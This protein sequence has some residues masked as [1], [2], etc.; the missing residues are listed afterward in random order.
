VNRQRLIVI[1]PLPPPYHGVTVSTS[2]VL[3]NPVLCDRFEVDH[4]DTSDHRTG[5]NIGRW[6]AANARLAMLAVLRLAHRL[7]GD[8]GVVYLPLSQSAPGL[9]RDSLFVFAA[10]LRGWKVAIHLRG[11]EFRGF[12]RRSHPILRRWIRATLAQVDSAAVMGHSLKGVFD[13]LIPAERIAVVPNGTPEPDP[14]PDV[15]RDP[16][17]VLFLSNLIPRKGVIEAVEAA[18]LVLATRH[19]ARFTFAGGC[20]SADFEQALRQRAAVAN[21]RIVF[22]APVVGAEKNQL[23]ASAAVLLFPPVEPEGHPRVIVEALAAGIPVITTDRG[24]IS[25][26]VIDGESGF[27]L[28]EPDPA[29]LAGCVLKLLDDQSLRERQSRAARD[30]YLTHFTQEQADRRLADWLASVANGR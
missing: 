26:T 18:L 21:G 13:G 25:E 22:V 8:T 14:V 28:D 9:L 27:V 4:L 29:A 24:A 12:Y 23:L 16:E 6:D 20:E 11:S 30:R 1:G 3:A 7:R 17:H 19:S 10:T 15:Q 2:L 5:G